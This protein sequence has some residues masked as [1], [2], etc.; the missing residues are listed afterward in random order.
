ME[1]STI[2]IGKC[3]SQLAWIKGNLNVYGTV[4]FAARERERK[5]V[6]SVVA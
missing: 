1:L 6:I 4:V 3:E 2:N 5:G